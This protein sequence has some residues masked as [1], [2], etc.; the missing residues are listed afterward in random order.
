ML[1]LSSADIFK[2]NF[3]KNFFQNTIRA[4]NGSDPDQD[5]LSVS[6]DLCLNCLKRQITEVPASKETVVQIF[7]VTMVTACQ[8]LI[9]YNCLENNFQ[10]FH[11]F[12]NIIVSFQ[13]YKA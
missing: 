9:L 5:R 11:A 12:Y 1:L 13:S 4:A 3:F 2:I 10:P 7:W 8:R 6:P